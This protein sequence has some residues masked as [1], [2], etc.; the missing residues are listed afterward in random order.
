M[1]LS[2]FISYFFI[3][4]IILIRISFFTLLERK[5][6]GYIQIR[7]GPNKVGFI[8]L[9]QPFADALK[10]FTKEINVPTIS[11]I[12]PF[13]FAPM[14]GLFLSLVLW[15]LYP[16]R[17]P[18]YM[19]NFSI[20][21][22]LCISSLS[23]YVTLIAGWTSNSKYALLGSLRSVAQTISYEVSISLILLRCLLIFGNLNFIYIFNYNYL[24]VFFLFFPLFLVWF[25]TML[26]ETNRTPFDFAEGESELVSGFNT[27]YSGGTFALIF[28]AEYLNILVMSLFSSLLFIIFF[29]INIIKDL[30][31]IIYTLFLSFLFIWIRGRLP[32]IRYDLLISLTWKGFLPFS[33]GVIILFISLLYILWYC[34]GWTD[35]F[36]DVKYEYFFNTS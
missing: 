22:F 23:V 17:S 13:M 2:R 1:R 16:S 19:F 29:N 36:D 4:L 11:N 26:A 33:L 35:N 34:A 32:R 15:L 5:V 31:L 3:Y 12:F 24:G 10:L 14:L 21:L 28:I 6:L 18:V 7:K 27:E 8:G 25:T 20:L 9:L 30:L